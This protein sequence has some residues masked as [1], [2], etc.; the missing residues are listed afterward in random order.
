[1]V[2]SETENSFCSFFGRLVR[3]S[4]KMVCTS[5]VGANSHEWSNGATPTTD[6]EAHLMPNFKI[7]LEDIIETSLPNQP[8]DDTL[9]TNK[10]VT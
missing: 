10:R 3:K 4:K 5:N 1:M 9:C 6:C 7:S 8:L 2:F